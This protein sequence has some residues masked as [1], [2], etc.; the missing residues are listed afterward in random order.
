MRSNNRVKGEPGDEASVYS[1]NEWFMLQWIGPIS[2]MHI[3][4]KKL[5]PRVT[6]A[7]VLVS[8][9][10][11]ESSTTI[12]QMYVLSINDGC[13]WDEEAMHL[14]RCLAFLQAKLDISVRLSHKRHSQYSSRCTISG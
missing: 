9:G 8:S 13:F 12:W 10:E 2:F 1:G 4:I 11:L 7:A 6:A 3:T 5:A 14:L